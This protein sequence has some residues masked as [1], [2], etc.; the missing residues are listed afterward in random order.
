MGV[1]CTCYWSF[2]V[3]E[4]IHDCV[5]YCGVREWVSSNVA[6]LRVPLEELQI[7]YKDAV[8]VAA[9]EEA[10]GVWH[11]DDGATFYA[12]F[13]SDVEPDI[14]FHVEFP[15]TLVVLEGKAE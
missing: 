7:G 14:V 9:S 3:C 13:V 5:T 4:E 11:V 2:A 1:V 6:P 10:M 15:Q 12:I 8:S